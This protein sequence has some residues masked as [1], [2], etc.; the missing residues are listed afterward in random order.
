MN[1]SGRF[2]VGTSDGANHPV[3]DAAG[4]FGACS[5]HEPTHFM[6]LHHAEHCNDWEAD[7]SGYDYDWDDFDEDLE[8]AAELKPESVHP[9]V[10][11]ATVVIADGV[12]MPAS[13]DDGVA[14]SAQPPAS[15]YVNASPK[16]ELSEDLLHIADSINVD[17]TATPKRTTA[18]A[19][20]APPVLAVR[21][22][23]SS[24]DFYGA[25][26]T[27]I[28]AGPSPIVDTF[29]TSG[30]VRGRLRRLRKGPMRR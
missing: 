9:A 22:R 1:T 4:V 30:R 5:S 14:I 24:S 26:I 8:F 11:V 6:H 27:I 20:G 3:G 29:G 28:A 19:R 17:F 7:D 10:P 25:I 21:Y 2:G 12:G 13:I 23:P 15:T 18:S 16:H